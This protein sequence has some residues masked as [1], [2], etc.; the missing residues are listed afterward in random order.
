MW[1]RAGPKEKRKLVVEQGR[2][3][4]EMLRGTKAVAQA[5]QGQ[6]WNW[7]GVEKKK[8][9]W[10][11]LWSMEERS[12]RFLMGATYDVLPTPQNLKR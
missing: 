2:R 3:H 6:W 8:L 11:E 10:K 4:E 1:S 12:I 9:S 7:E 5:K